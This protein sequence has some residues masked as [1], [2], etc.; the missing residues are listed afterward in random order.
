M[1]GL[2]TWPADQPRHA[3]YAS[4]Y[5]V[6]PCSP[7]NPPC[8]VAVD[9]LI[10]IYYIGTFQQGSGIFVLDELQLDAR[11][12]RIVSPFTVT[13]QSYRDSSYL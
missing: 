9:S 10:V 8:S 3:T 5:P 7:P 6:E 4:G 2:L 12:Y 1:V 11:P 13:N